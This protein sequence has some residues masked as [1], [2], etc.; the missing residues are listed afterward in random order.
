MKY[1]IKTK[2]FP[3]YNNLQRTNHYQNQN[4]R[5][6]TVR[7]AEHRHNYNHNVEPVNLYDRARRY[8]NNARAYKRAAQKIE[9]LAPMKAVNANKELFLKLMVKENNEEKSYLNEITNAFS[10]LHRINKNNKN[11]AE[12]MVSG[13]GEYRKKVNELLD[14]EKTNTFMTDVAKINLINMAE[15]LR[16]DQLT[17]KIAANTLR[18]IGIHIIYKDLDFERFEESGGLTKLK[19]VLEKFND[20]DKDIY[21][22]HYENLENNLNK[23]KNK[24]ESDHEKEMALSSTMSFMEKILSKVE[25]N[26]G[27]HE[28]MKKLPE[29]P[30]TSLWVSTISAEK[31]ARHF[32]F[33]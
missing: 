9:Y 29:I 15:N 13:F 14:E 16:A 25:E 7:N 22:K 10:E 3:N 27:M 4:N 8:D 11:I 31:T 32:Y 5:K 28:I 33:Y 24:C 23:I 6:L 26:N 2:K 18:N 17:L 30:K 19:T 21:R 20:D 12:N 1:T